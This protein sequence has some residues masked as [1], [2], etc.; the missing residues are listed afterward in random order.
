VAAWPEE[1]EIELMPARTPTINVHEVLHSDEPNRFKCL[2]FYSSL[3]TVAVAD[4]VYKVVICLLCKR[5]M[6]PTVAAGHFTSSKKVKGVELS[7]IH[8][9][10]ISPDYKELDSYFNEVAL[11]LEQI[12]IEQVID[13][14]AK[15]IPYL[16]GF[17]PFK[18][19]ACPTCYNA[20]VKVQTVRS[21]N[22]Q[23]EQRSPEKCT[24]IAVPANEKGSTKWIKVSD[25][26]RYQVTPQAHDYTGP[27]VLAE[28]RQ[29]GNN[30]SMY[31]R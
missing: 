18:G 11:A 16:K 22:C 19:H 8:G 23:C 5:A 3:G 20:S 27:T 10:I 25:I 28:L 17:I 31:K 13:W 1:H 30:P 24:V 12:P 6:F 21:M 9:N 26:D 29:Q 15:S 2:A 7:P 14:K 4:T